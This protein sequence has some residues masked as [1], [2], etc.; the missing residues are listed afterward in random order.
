MKSRGRDHGF[1]SVPRGGGK[2]LPA[3][4][5]RIVAV[6]TAAQTGGAYTLLEVIRTSAGAAPLHTHENEDE[7]FYVRSGTWEVTCG[8][9]TI[10]ATP[11]SFVFLP[12]G[13][14]H[15]Y[16]VGARGGRSLIICSPGG[17]ERYFEKLADAYKR[18]EFTPLVHRSIARRYGVIHHELSA[19]GEAGPAAGSER[20]RRPS[21]R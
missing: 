13:V 8:D 4:G 9:R 11:G 20:D 17:I 6:A 14:P 2:D 16:G 3:Q 18:G 12:R 1:F 19:V 5:F 21:R 7:A 10:K 15:K